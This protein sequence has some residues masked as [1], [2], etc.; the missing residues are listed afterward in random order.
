MYKDGTS[1]KDLNPIV[2]VGTEKSPLMALCAT[3][4]MMMFEASTGKKFSDNMDDYLSYCD[5]YRD[6]YNASLSNEIKLTKVAN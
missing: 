1:F 2:N 4:M 3:T 5:G 6:A